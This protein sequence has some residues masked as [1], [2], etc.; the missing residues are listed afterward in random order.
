MLIKFIYSI[1]FSL[2]SVC[3]LPIFIIKGKGRGGIGSRLGRV[4]D[5]VCKRLDGKKVIW[6]HAVSVGEVALATRLITHWRSI[7]QS[8]R[9]VLTVTTVAGYEVAQ[10]GKHTEDVVLQ[11]PVDFRF[12]VRRFISAIKPSAVV[13]IETEIWPNL[14]WEVSE[15]KVPM[16]IMN[17]RISDKAIGKYRRIRGFIGPLLRR[18]TAIAAQDER[19]RLRFVELGADAAKVWQAGNLKFDW[20]PSE[21]VAPDVSQAIQRLSSG[22]SFLFLAASTH[23]GEDEVMMDTYLWLKDK[24]P[25]FGLLLAPRHLERIASIQ[26]LADKKGIVLK[27]I[28]TDANNGY[29]VKGSS[30]WVLDR[31]GVLQHLYAAASAVFVGGSLVSVGG[32]NPA[33]PAYYGKPVLFGPRMD[34]FLEMSRLFTEGG[35]ASTVR[36]GLELRQKLLLLAVDPAERRRIGENAKNILSSHQGALDRC[37]RI[38]SQLTEEVLK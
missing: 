11:F 13:M 5:E 1:L 38:F 16:F 19:M 6:V 8:A 9:F 12:S 3:Y 36:N 21:N 17:G 18:F 27:K 32:H 4:D 22:G 30:V 31:M 35:A 25:G 28:F 37:T 24:I 10:K 15:R 20:R 7:F 29:D 2:F 26:A 14:I 34:N 23:Q 33:E